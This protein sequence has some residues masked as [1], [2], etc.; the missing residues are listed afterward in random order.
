MDYACSFGQSHHTP[1]LW[2]K[3]AQGQGLMVEQR[4]QNQS[5]APAKGTDR[6]QT[7]RTSLPVRRSWPALRHIDHRAARMRPGIAPKVLLELLRRGRHSTLGETLQA[8]FNLTGEPKPFAP[9]AAE[10]WLLS[11]EAGRYQGGRHEA[12]PLDHL[13]P[14]ECV[15]FGPAPWDK[16]L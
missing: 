16:Y 13:L 14:Y 9:P 3:P 1:E 7:S 5:P 4:H 10:T 2:E 12:L 6:S 8:M 11:S 15:A